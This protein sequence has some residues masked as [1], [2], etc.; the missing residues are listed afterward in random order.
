MGEF[1]RSRHHVHKQREDNVTHGQEVHTYLP[2]SVA[3]QG[4]DLFRLLEKEEQSLTC[5]PNGGGPPCLN[6]SEPCR[7]A[8]SQCDEGQGHFD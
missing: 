8:R 1:L 7:R 3:L 5:D 2:G 4:A 6:N